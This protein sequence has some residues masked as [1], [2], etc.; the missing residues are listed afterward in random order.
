MPR[1]R[2]LSRLKRKW[3]KLVGSD[4]RMVYPH[5]IIP[6][7]PGCTCHPAPNHW[8]YEEDRCQQPERV[9]VT[10]T[11]LEDDGGGIYTQWSFGIFGPVGYKGTLKEGD[12][13]AP[14]QSRQDFAEALRLE[15]LFDWSLVRQAGMAAVIGGA[16][17]ATLI[18]LA[19]TARCNFKR[20]WGSDP[21]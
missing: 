9:S 15:R 4:F 16:R 11:L 13:V 7:T 2:T 3:V 19:Q 14:L 12:A 6:H 21:T 8:F 1:I 18:E 5:K 10:P 20:R 17:N